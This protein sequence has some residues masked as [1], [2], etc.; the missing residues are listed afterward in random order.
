MTKTTCYICVEGLPHW[1][2]SGFSELDQRMACKAC[3]GNWGGKKVII[4]VAA[5]DQLF[6][7]HPEWWSITA[8]IKSSIF[9]KP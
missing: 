3:R 7:A 6:S 2:F 8:I 5:L 9:Q 4:T 1:N